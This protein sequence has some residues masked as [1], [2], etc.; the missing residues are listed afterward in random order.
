MI[1]EIPSSACVGAASSFR[2]TIA[3]ARAKFDGMFTATSGFKTANIPVRL[4]GVGFFDVLHGQTGVAPNGIELHPVLDVLFNPRSACAP[5]AT[6]LCLDDQPGDGRFQI[7]VDYATTQ[8]GGSA[9]EAHAIPLSALGTTHGGLM[10]FF[11][12]DNP[13]LL[14][15]ILPKCAGNGHF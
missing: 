8:G 4:T 15:K 6:T 9:G 7:E 3:A 14:I 5:S 10:W 1:T 13:E 12:A 11:E 2:T